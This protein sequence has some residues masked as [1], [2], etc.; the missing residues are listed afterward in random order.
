MPLLH[1]LS[2]WFLKNWSSLLRNW[3]FPFFVFV[4]FV[5]IKLLVISSFN[6]CCFLLN[7]ISFINQLRYQFRTQSFSFIIIRFKN[8]VVI[9]VLIH[10]YCQL[11]G[12]W[13]FCLKDITFLLFQRQHVKLGYQKLPINQLTHQYTQ[14]FFKKNWE[15]CLKLSFLLCNILT[16][17]CQL[18]SNCRKEW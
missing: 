16:K 6:S 5:I 13:P 18:I 9:L 12:L 10:F 15:W 17:Y 11:I 8:F 14:L 1:P 2:I 3:D 4:T 7:H